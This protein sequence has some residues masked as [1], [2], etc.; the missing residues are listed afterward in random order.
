MVSEE[1]RDFETYRF[2]LYGGITAVLLSFLWSASTSKG[3][4]GALGSSGLIGIIGIVGLIGLLGFIG[5]LF[6]V[7]CLSPYM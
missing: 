5:I 7:I 2:F 6:L 4:L 1:E 3:T